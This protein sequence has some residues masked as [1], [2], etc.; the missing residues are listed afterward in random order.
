MGYE[1]IIDR[2]TLFEGPAHILYDKPVDKADWRYCWS[3]GDVTVNLLRTGKEVVV[4]GLGQ[5]DDPAKD[6][7]IEVEFT[8]S[9]NISGGLLDWMFSDVFTLKPGMSI[10][11]AADTP[12]WVHSIDGKILE[13]SNARVT[14]FPTLQFGTGLARFSGT[15]K[16]TGIIRKGVARCEADCLF[17]PIVAEPFTAI[18]DR[19]EWV[20]LPCL[21]TWALAAPRTIMTSQDGWTFTAG[22]TI[23]PR[24]NPDVGTFDFR[25]EQVNVTAACT[26]INVSDADLLSAAVIGEN[27]RLGVS[28]ANADLTL[29]EDY[30][31]ITAVLRNARLTAKPIVY[32]EGKP[33][34]GQLTWQAFYGKG[35]IASLGYSEE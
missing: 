11:G 26:P 13:I 10:F 12:V 7:I 25:L 19:G 28:G 5:I 20:H 17:K 24:V 6:E 29:A 9:G 33:R 30:P 16:M 34:A 35:G 2:T 8:P 23:S 31:G 21:A 15:A 22:H 14:Q 32:G 4:S 18:P 1:P 3:A 27:R